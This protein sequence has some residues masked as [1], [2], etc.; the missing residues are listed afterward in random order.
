MRKTI[1][2]GSAKPDVPLET[3][4]TSK[5]GSHMQVTQDEE[6]SSQPLSRFD[7]PFSTD[8]LERYLH[9]PSMKYDELWVGNVDETD[10]AR[11]DDE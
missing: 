1:K 3:H 5:S 2:P 8:S 6:R 7:F 9:D 10:E 11:P 4:T